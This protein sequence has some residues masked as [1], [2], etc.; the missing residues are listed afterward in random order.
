MKEVEY[1]QNGFMK[2]MSDLKASLRGTHHIVRASISRCDAEARE[3]HYQRTGRRALIEHEDTPLKEG[4]IEDLNLQINQIQTG[5]EAGSKRG[6]HRRGAYDDKVIDPMYIQK[7]FQPSN[8]RSAST[9]SDDL[10]SKINLA[11]EDLPPQEWKSYVMARGYCARVDEIAGMLGVSIRSVRCYLKRADKKV[12]AALE[13][14]M[15]LMGVKWDYA[16]EME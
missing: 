7:F 12:K 8:S 1:D 5:R 15:L 9:L 13:G 10:I 16:E 6:I 4:M 11:L 2:H 14:N 3:E